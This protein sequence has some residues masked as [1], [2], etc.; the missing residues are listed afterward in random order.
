MFSHFKQELV[1]ITLYNDLGVSPKPVTLLLCT[2]N[3]ELTYVIKN[4]TNPNFLPDD[5]SLAS[6]AHASAA[7]KLCFFSH[8][9]VLS[10]GK[11]KSLENTTCVIAASAG[12]C[13]LP[14]ITRQGAVATGRVAPK[15][16][17]QPS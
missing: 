12:S 17:K 1:P 10:K 6:T 8:V 5:T 7:P 3:E 16:N 9:F 15:I 13:S 11:K 4:S 2:G 14:V